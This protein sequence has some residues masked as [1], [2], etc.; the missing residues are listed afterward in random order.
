MI[1]V[2][3]GDYLQKNM[4]KHFRMIKTL[5]LLIVIMIYDNTHYIKYIKLYTKNE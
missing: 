3:E 1:R 4:R 5:Y 2:A